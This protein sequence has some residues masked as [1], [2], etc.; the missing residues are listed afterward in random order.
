MESSRLQTAI[1]KFL[2]LY[3]GDEVYVRKVYQMRKPEYHIFSPQGGFILSFMIHNEYDLNIERPERISVIG[4]HK[5]Y[6]M[7]CNFF[8]IT[9]R[10][11]MQYLR[12]WFGDKHNIKK[13]GDIKKFIP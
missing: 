3:F 8:L 4:S 5:T 11:A 9:H 12:D 2:D 10:E 13:V 1:Y 7:L 6:E